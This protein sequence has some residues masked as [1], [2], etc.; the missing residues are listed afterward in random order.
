MLTAKV[1]RNSQRMA[2]PSLAIMLLDQDRNDLLT[3]V[4]ALSGVTV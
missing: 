3:G 4:C 2:G 1:S